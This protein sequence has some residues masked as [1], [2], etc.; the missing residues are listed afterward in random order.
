MSDSTAVVA[1]LG[2]AGACV[3][4]LSWLAKYL[5]VQFKKSLD[6][7]A[8]AQEKNANATIMN[9]RVSEET[10]TFMKKLNGR[11]AEITAEKINE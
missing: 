9:T 5:L 1:A 3:T 4:V 11:L 10:L 2:I 7:N 8:A 6:K